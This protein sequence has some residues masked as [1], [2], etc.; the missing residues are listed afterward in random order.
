VF[1]VG[2][3]LGESS[4]REE[5]C[6]FRQTAIVGAFKFGTADGVIGLDVLSSF[7]SVTFD[8]KEFYSRS[9]RQMSEQ[10]Y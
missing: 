9:G 4:L 7:A 2:F 8:F 10:G 5:R 1:H 3:T 6:S